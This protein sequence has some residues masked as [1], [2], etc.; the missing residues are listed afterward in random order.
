MI[1]EKEIRW[2]SFLDSSWF[3]LNNTVLCYSWHAFCTELRQWISDH[4]AQMWSVSQVLQRCYYK[5]QESV[6]AY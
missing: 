6:K 4:R 5:F 1:T 3:I 2:S